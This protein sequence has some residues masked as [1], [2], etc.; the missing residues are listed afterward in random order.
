[1]ARLDPVDPGQLTGEQ[2]KVYDMIATGPRG[3]VRGPFLALLHVPEMCE[4]VQHLGEYLRY[5]T[6][7]S[8]KLAELAI[9]TT[10][11]GLRCH[12]E[13]FAHARIA[14]E[15]GLSAQ[16]IEA[17]RTNRDPELIDPEE[18]LVYRFAHELVTGQRVSGPT[19]EGVVQTFGRTGAVEL[20]GIVGYY[21][22]IA[23]TLNA[24]DIEP[25]PPLPLTD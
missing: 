5:G 13:W 14:A 21:S 19:Y 11:R 17:I 12:Y 18:R 22:M 3:G 20:A 16:A 15:N 24:H 6:S 10:A 8:R 23:A 4:R 25:P 2:R 1:M 7:F 9:I